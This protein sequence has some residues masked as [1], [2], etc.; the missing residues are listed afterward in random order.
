MNP[1]LSELRQFLWLKWPYAVS[2][3]SVARPSH[4]RYWP[5]HRLS[6]QN[7]T[8]GTNQQCLEMVWYENVMLDHE[9]TIPLEPGSKTDWTP[10]IGKEDT[11][12]PSWV[13]CEIR[14][15]GQ[16]RTSTLWLHSSWP[17]LITLHSSAQTKLRDSLSSYRKSK[18]TWQCLSFFSLP[19]QNPGHL[20][21][22]LRRILEGWSK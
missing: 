9:Y 20:W 4:K 2:L 6:I 1:G 3:G 22:G 12:K 16:C 5:R 21:R 8:Y 10:V 18:L 19:T 13:W 15:Q 14:E 7:Q 17:C 11:Q